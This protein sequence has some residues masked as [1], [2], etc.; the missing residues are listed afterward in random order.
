MN[1]LGFAS[2]EQS[3]SRLLHH[4]KMIS[5]SWALEALESSNGRAAAVGL[6]VVTAWL[7]K[8]KKL[9]QAVLVPVDIYPQMFSQEGTGRSA[10]GERRCD[11]V[12]I[13]LKRNIVDATFIEVKWRR[14]LVPLESLAQDMVLQMEGSAQ[15]MKER[16]F[17][18][19]RVDGA[20]QRSYLANVLR[21][22]FERSRRYGLFDPE[23]A[24]SFLEHVTRLEKTGL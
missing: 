24:A 8:N 20:L 4:L 12:L 19:N 11:L 9:R 3:V 22:Y 16:F 5:G 14:G 21:F 1:E 17:S 6:G 7:E 15:T 13:S 10:R 18:E 2:I 23:A